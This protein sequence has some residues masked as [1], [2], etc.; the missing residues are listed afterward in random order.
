VE[1]G[2]LSLT[3][4]AQFQS[5]ATDATGKTDA[6][7]KRP[8]LLSPEA[9]MMLA[10]SIMPNESEEE[11]LKQ[12]EGPTGNEATE[13]HSKASEEV[14]EAKPKHSLDSTKQKDA[15]EEAQEEALREFPKKPSR[16]ESKESSRKESK[17]SSRKESKESSRKESKESSRKKSKEAS[18][19][20]LRETSG[21]SPE[22]ALKL[23]LE[24]D[25]VKLGPKRL[26]KDTPKA[27]P[28]A[29]A[30]QVEDTSEGTAKE[31][32]E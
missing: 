31:T 25:T 17:E 9:I 21:E 32:V 26:A 28:E 23:G 7:M 10:S 19:Q 29:I 15:Q 2:D 8:I 16:K 14:L 12:T 11:A 13:E 6:G 18:Q 27:T 30:K 5:L 1:P 3:M 22:T 20:P 24:K 4:A